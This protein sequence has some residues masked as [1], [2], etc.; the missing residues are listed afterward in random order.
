LTIDGSCVPAN[1]RVDECFRYD[2]I[3]AF[4]D[5]VEIPRVWPGGWTSTQV[6]EPLPS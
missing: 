6:F 5:G 2:D 1:F 3:Q 4:V